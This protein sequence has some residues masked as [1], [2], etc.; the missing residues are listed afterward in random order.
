MDYSA[1]NIQLLSTSSISP[2]PLNPR[3]YRD[4]VEMDALTDSIRMLGIQQPITVRPITDGAAYEIVMGERRYRAACAADL[5]EIPCIVRE[6]SDEELVIL[7]IEENVKRADLSAIELAH[8]YR[9][10]LGEGLTQ[11]ALAKRLGVSQPSIS[12]SLRLLRLPEIVQEHLMVRHLSGSHGIALC[13]L[14]DHPEDCIELAEV[15]LRGSLSLADLEARVKDRKSAIE[16][17][18]QPA[19]PFPMAAPVGGD[20]DGEKGGVGPGEKVTTTN[21]TKVVHEGAKPIPASLGASPVKENYTQADAKREFEASQQKDPDA[22]DMKALAAE[23]QAEAKQ[24][25]EAKAEETPAPKSSSAPAS[26]DGPRMATTI[27]VAVDDWLFENDLTLDQ[28]LVEAIR[29]K[30]A[31]ALLGLGA[32]PELTALG[33]KCLKAITPESLD[34]ASFLEDILVGR[35]RAE[36]FDIAVLTEIPE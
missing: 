7:A 10:A 1:L 3:K 35:A 29:A 32:R 34:P 9:S 16:Q 19:L 5:A 27:P 4:E 12:N 17:K 15:A 22:I 20:E 36:G 33:F 18:N 26:M 30:T 2:S 25:E 14:L 21:T 6:M 31:E 24:A 28:L 23:A 13:S 8:G 11:D